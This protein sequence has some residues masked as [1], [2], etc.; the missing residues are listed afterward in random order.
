MPA[1]GQH[2]SH[3]RL[4]LADE[5]IPVVCDPERVAQILRILIDNAITHTPQGTNMIVRA[6][7]SEGGVKLTVRD[8]G[9]GIKRTAMAH[10]F[11]PSTPPTACRARVWGWRSRASWPSGGGTLTLESSPG[12]TVFTLELPA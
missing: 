7:P 3:L 1:L 11:E 5:P 4:H 12:R 2:S 8:F 10:V 6:G 9:P